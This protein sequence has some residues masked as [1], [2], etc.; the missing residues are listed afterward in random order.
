MIDKSSKSTANSGEGVGDPVKIQ[1]IALNHNT[2]NEQTKIGFR[3]LGGE[4]N[5]DS[6]IAM[7]ETDFVDL[8]NKR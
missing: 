6:W 1:P 4:Y 8:T 2:L 7:D 3:F 5:Y